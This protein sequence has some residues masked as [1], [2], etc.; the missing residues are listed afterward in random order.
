MSE[1][2]LDASALLAALQGERGSEKL[3]PDFLSTA[4]ISTVNVAEIQ[5]KLVSRGIA[6][7][8]AWESIVR[9]VGEIVPFSPE[10]AK[11]AGDL[12]AETHM[13]GLSL[14]DRACLALGFLTKAAVYTTDSSWAKL[15]LGI[16]IHV[17]R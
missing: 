14:G 8:D 1:S 16:R 6:R 3:T 11:M 12:V 10:H 9:A 17:I 2:V 15:K 5:T 4:K 13:L 7:E